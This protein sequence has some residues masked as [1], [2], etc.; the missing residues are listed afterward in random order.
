V[1]HAHDKLEDLIR[2][3]ISILPVLNRFG[4][5]LGFHSSTLEKF[6]KAYEINID[7]FLTIVNAYIHEEYFPEKELSNFEPELIIDYLRKTHRY[8]INYKIPRMDMLFE[9]LIKVD[10]NSNETQPIYRFYSEYKTELLNHFKEEEA[11]VFPYLLELI[12]IEKKELTELSKLFNNHPVKHY[13][14]EHVEADAKLNDLKSLLIQYIAPIYD[15]NA[16]NEFL[17]FIED[18]DKDLKDHSRIEDKILVPHILRLEKKL[19]LSN[20]K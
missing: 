12:S 9:A 17:F 19:N 16:C 5:R 1:Y 15:Y 3:N 4:M 7:F 14:D 2:E 13:E 8:Y 11:F 20:K 6:C 10:I 18:F